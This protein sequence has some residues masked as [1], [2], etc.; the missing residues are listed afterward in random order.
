MKSIHLL[1]SDTINKIAAG[2]VVE[3]PS[4]VIKE[5]VENAI[6]AK[7]SAITIEIKEG[8]IAMMRVTDNGGGIDRD[9]IKTAFVRHATSKIETAMDLMTVGSL[10]FRGEALSSIASVSQIELITKVHRELLG[11]RYCIDGGE[12][13]SCDDIGCPDGTTIIVR[14]LFYN[15]PA[16]RKFLKT[17]ATE[18]AYINDLAGRLALSHPDVSFKFINN[19]Q[20]RLH[21]SGNGNL[22]DIIYQIY[23]RDV[24]GQLLEVDVQ[25][26]LCH[27]TGFIGKPILS[28]GNRS[29]ENYFINGRY[30][31]SNIITKAIEDAY[32]TFVMIHKYPFT[33][34]HIEVD[35]ALIDVNAWKNGVR[36]NQNEAVYQ[37]IYDIIR[38]VLNTG[39]HTSHFSEDQKRR[40]GKKE[41]NL[42]RT[43]E[44]QRLAA[45]V[46]RQKKPEQSSSAYSKSTFCT[47]RFSAKSSVA[48]GSGYS[49]A[50]YPNQGADSKPYTA[51][52]GQSG[53]A[54]VRETPT[55]YH[56]KEM[57]TQSTSKL[58]DENN[59]AVMS[60]TTEEQKKTEVTLSEAAEKAP[61]PHMPIV[62]E[63]M[64]LFGEDERLLDEKARARHRLIGQVFDTYWMVEYD[65]KLFIIDQH[66][67]HEKVLYEK[68]MKAFSQKALQK[69][70][71]SPPVILTL[72]MQEENIYKQYADYF[73][74][75]G[76]E[77]ELFGGR[78]YAVRGV[79]LQLFGMNARDI[80]IEVLDSVTE[81]SRRLDG[82]AITDHIATMACKAAVKGNNKLSFKEADTLIEQLLQA[83]N[84]YTCPHG[85]PTIISLSK[86][87]LEKKFK[88][89]QS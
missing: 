61:K 20:N 62:G 82:S 16:R 58:Q 15:T 35:P 36:F 48:A 55:A 3:R 31:K 52:T 26:K 32:K 8:G 67:A 42:V 68:L 86:Y 81:E 57:M 5:L 1:D 70:M 29:W 73:A 53:S 83:K 80:F 13:K 40:T 63:Q 34:F 45:M 79:P 41:R 72:S 88:R 38:A 17:A 24:T 65:G 11:V 43:F 66:A 77:I 10:G 84:P 7:A 60:E 56:H 59:R 49:A 6:D 76:F 39:S 50:S 54:F 28:R 37:E 44:L 12:E 69:Q 87:E 14:N 9:D 23:G 89:I 19:N 47:N 27:V 30:I 71:L 51:P 78:E 74:E 75:L 22:R 4:S 64:Q 18:A 21:T 2:E 46:A 25:G 33:A 85:R